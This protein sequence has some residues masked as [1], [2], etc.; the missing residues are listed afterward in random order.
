[1]NKLKNKLSTFLIFLLFFICSVTLISNAKVTYPKPTNLKYINDYVNLLSNSDKE[2]IVSIGKDLEDKTSAQAVVVIINST[3]G[4]PIEEYSNKLF[5]TWGIGTA[6]KDNGLLILLAVNDNKYR[7]EVGRGLEGALPD[8]LT[9]RVMEALAIPNFK[10]RKYGTGIVESYSKFSDYIAQEYGV[11]LEKSLNIQLPS[12]FKQQSSTKRGLG[13]A[14]ILTLFLI[15]FDMIFNRGRILS[16]LLQLFFW[17]NFF[18]DGRRGG[19]SS[20]NGGGFGGF[21]GGSSNGGGSS[22]D[23]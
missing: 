22:G 11:T 9:H 19:G 6:S 7:V 15:L 1:M 13:L 10:E 16:F 8:V 18:G 12:N 4:T 5:R 21:G 14:G 20:N 23:W 17:N 2:K 3:Q